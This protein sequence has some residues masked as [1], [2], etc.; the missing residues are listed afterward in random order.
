LAAIDG[1]SGAAGDGKR[2]D[3]RDT[4]AVHVRVGG[5]AVAE[6][7]GLLGEPWPGERIWTAFGSAGL[8]DASGSAIAA[9]RRRHRRHTTK[10]TADL[11]FFFLGGHNCHRWHTDG[12]ADPAAADVHVHGAGKQ[13]GGDDEVDVARGGGPVPRELPAVRASAAAICGL[14]AT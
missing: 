14:V 9:T 12:G 3:G 7:V 1:E 11:P 2:R 8:A 4:D 13:M 5:I 6:G 10:L